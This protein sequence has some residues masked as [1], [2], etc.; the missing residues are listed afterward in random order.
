[1]PSEYIYDNA[2]NNY[3]ENED[4]YFIKMRSLL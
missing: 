4:D 3:C 1:M 2:G